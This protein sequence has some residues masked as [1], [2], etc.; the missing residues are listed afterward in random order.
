[1]TLKNCIKWRSVNKTNYDGFVLYIFSN[2]YQIFCLPG[3]VPA[4]L[5]YVFLLLFIISSLN[6]FKLQK[7]ELNYGANKWASHNSIYWIKL[8]NGVN[9]ILFWAVLSEKLPHLS[10]FR[11]Y[12]LFVV[13][14][15]WYSQMWW[16][17]VAIFQ[18]QCHSYQVSAKISI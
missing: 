4:T 9:T 2:I 12:P 7:I 15:V 8:E 5:R 6:D 1:M 14:M 3:S 16:E 18:L 17:D 11:F 13:T 10:N